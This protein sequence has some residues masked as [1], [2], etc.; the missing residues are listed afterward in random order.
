MRPKV[1]I[2]ILVAGFGLLGI[3]VVFK[4]VLAGHAGNTGGQAPA[5]ETKVDSQQSPA[6][7]D[8]A[9]QVNP[10]SSNAAAGSEQMRVAAVEREL[11]AIRAL[12]TRPMARII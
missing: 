5:P 4:G 3:M 9:V 12:W 2:L 8:Q 10:N 11:D 1:V 7:N 6:T